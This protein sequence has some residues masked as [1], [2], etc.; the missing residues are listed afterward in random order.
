MFNFRQKR[1]P[2]PDGR[3]LALEAALAVGS[4]VERNVLLAEKPT[5]VADRLIRVARDCRVPV[6]RILQDI[7]GART[8]RNVVLDE[9]FKVMGPVG[10]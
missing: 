3:S 4:R 5:L 1:R 7:R 6:T 8:A 9:N 2:I 10:S